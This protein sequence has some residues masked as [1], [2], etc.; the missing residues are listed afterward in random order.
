MPIRYRLEENNLK[1]GTFYARVIPGD[2]ITLEQMLPAIVAKTSLSAADV[3]ASITALIDEVI[4]ALAVG[5]RPVIDGLV[6]FAA[7][8][9]GSFETVEVSLNS[10]TAHLNVL[11]QDDHALA[12]AVAARTSY[13]R[14]LSEVKA[15]LVN[16]VFDIAGSSYDHYTPGSIVRLKGDNLKFDP[17]QSDEGVFI[18]DG[19]SETRL[20]VYSVAGAR[21]IDT[22]IPAGVSGS[23]TITVRARYTE[24]GE[25]RQGS[26]PRPVMMA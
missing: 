8:L 10:D 4:A 20:T 13:V 22:L 23:L 18:H 14:E 16:S 12:A 2:I 26:Y 24:T 15:P 25:L 5:D 21:Q 19:S 6:R 17:T 11:A 1:P 7:S 9:S 3:Q